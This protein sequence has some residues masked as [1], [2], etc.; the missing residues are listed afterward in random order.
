MD[1]MSDKEKRKEDIAKT[2]K[3]PLFP[4]SSKNRKA[5]GTTF[6][7]THS[8]IGGYVDRKL[9]DLISLYCVYNEESKTTFIKKLIDEKAKEFPSER[10]MM[11]QICRDQLQNWIDYIE[12]YEYE[13]DI[14]Y[15]HKKKTLW[16]GYKIALRKKLQKTIPKYYTSFVINYIEEA[17]F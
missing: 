11:E 9:M 5:F 14:L 15:N 1:K 10:N 6:F 12:S 4:H 7:E 13:N 2:F 17:H 8:L 3:Y 16:N